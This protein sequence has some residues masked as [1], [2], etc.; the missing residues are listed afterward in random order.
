[1]SPLGLARLVSTVGGR[2]EAVPP[3]GGRW[4]V[5]RASHSGVLE[6]HPKLQATHSMLLASHS[7]LLESRSGLLAS[8]SGLLDS[9][10]FAGEPI[11][12]MNKRLKRAPVVGRAVLECQRSPTQCPD[13]RQS[14]AV[15]NI[16][17]FTFALLIFPAGS[18]GPRTLIRA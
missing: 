11:G 6:S 5:H 8:H 10:S 14:A 12:A 13:R 18:S 15:R 3:L 2:L 4:V 7:G 9:H 17:S 16:E 1:M